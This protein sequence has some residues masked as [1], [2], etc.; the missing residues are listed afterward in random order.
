MSV[1]NKMLQDLEQRNDGNGNEPADYQKKQALHTRKLLLF[2]IILL[3]VA[4]GYF[5][6]RHVGSAVFIE[7]FEKLGLFEQEQPR[8]KSKKV[9]V[10]SELD[11]MMPAR[12][13]NDNTEATAPVENKVAQSSTVEQ[14]ASM[15]ASQAINTTSDANPQTEQPSDV[16]KEASLNTGAAEDYTK[17]REGEMSDALEAEST[18]DE[19][20]AM[21]DDSS[22]ASGKETFEVSRS[23]EMSVEDKIASLL[24]AANEAVQAER[25]PS[26]IAAFNAILELQPS[27]H[28][29]RKR[30]AVL[31]YSNDQESDAE[32][33][34]RQGMDLAPDR[35]DLR[36]MLGRLLH[37]QQKTTELYNVLKV[38]RP[39]VE[40]NSEYI[41]LL[42]MAAQQLNYHQEASEL[43]GLLASYEPEQSRWWLGIAISS[44]KMQNVPLALDAYRRVQDLNQL[45]VSVME[46]VKQRIKALG[47]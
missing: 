8:E 10:N 39:S 2:I 25:I 17:T 36:L 22:D 7:A 12:S 23:A 46:F 19:A 45:S 14:S 28:D 13:G 24:T 15:T 44:D 34:L 5:S 47:G 42:A 11:R 40:Q 32:T 26:A 33:L 29:V 43:Y 18:M 35:I 6:F 41:S 31:L 1:V 20:T 9:S 4:I 38:V 30:L 3:L 37:R 21:V 16:Q 27:R